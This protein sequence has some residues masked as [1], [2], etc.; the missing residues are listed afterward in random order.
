MWGKKTPLSLWP[1]S[2]LAFPVSPGLYEIFFSCFTLF[3]LCTCVCE[4]A[5]LWQPEEDVKCL[6]LSLPT[7]LP[8]TAPLSEPGARLV[9]CSPS[10]L[11]LQR[12]TAPSSFLHGLWVFELRSCP[13]AARPLN[14]P[15]ILLF[16]LFFL[17]PLKENLTT[18]LLRTF[19]NA[20]ISASE[21]LRLCQ[22]PH[23]LVLN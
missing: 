17:L 11:G 6:D 14:H 15:R 9:A 1:S 23:Q 7:L 16:C 13:W 18:G 20:P 21:V 2:N 12:H 10:V 5:S 3:C 8:C 19:H 4:C 22:T